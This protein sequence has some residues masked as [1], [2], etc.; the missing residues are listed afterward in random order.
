MKTR[1]LLAVAVLAATPVLGCKDDGGSGSRCGD[2]SACGGE[3]TGTWTVDDVCLEGDFGAVLQTE[4]GL[5]DA[6]DSFAKSAQLT[7]AGTLDFTNGVQTTALSRTI[8]AQATQA[9]LSAKAGT[10]IPMSQ[11]IC[12]A[13]A[14][15][16]TLTLVDLVTCTLGDNACNCTAT[17]V[18][19]QVDPYTVSGGTVTYTADGTTRDFCVS[20]NTLT[21]RDASWYES[22]PALFTAHR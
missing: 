13:L 16:M 20:A 11:A 9:C 5:P 7:V 2:F 12:T 19:A 22:L 1:T 8:T 14:A 15:E 18:I 3:L 21:S 6:C 10:T 17:G 4:L